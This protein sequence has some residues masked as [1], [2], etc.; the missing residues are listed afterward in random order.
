MAD[1]LNSTVERLRKPISWL[2]VLILIAT[3]MV[4]VPAHFEDGWHEALEIF[5]YM[6]LIAAGMGRIWCLIYIAGKKDR[7]LCTEGPYSIC[8][9]PLYLFS[10]IGVIGAFLALQSILLAAIAST[11]YLLYYYFVVESEE[12]RLRDIFQGAFLDYTKVTPRFLPAFSAYRSG[13]AE[14]IIST[15]AVERGLREV[16]WFFVAIALID[17]IEVI[18]SQGIL[19]F[20]TLPF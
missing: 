9:N 13:A 15:Q 1:K 18:H 20:A 7:V 10:F 16:V 14:R 8:R 6:C 11:A 4:T 17:T 12:R 19:V 5:G 2:I 3:A